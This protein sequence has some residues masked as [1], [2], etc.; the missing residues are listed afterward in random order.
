MTDV[1]EFTE[2]IYIVCRCMHEHHITL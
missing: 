2:E 1:Y